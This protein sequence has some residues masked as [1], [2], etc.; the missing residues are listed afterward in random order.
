MNPDGGKTASVEG[1][2]GRVLDIMAEGLGVPVGPE[3]DVIQ[4]GLMDSLNF[5]DLLVRLE[6][7]FGVRIDVEDVELDDFRTARSIADYL[8]RRHPA[9]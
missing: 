3:V 2:E 1:L 8:S 6:E 7:A 5:V 9:A 4:R